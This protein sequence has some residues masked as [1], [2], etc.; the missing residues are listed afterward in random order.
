M[1]R[2][3]HPYPPKNLSAPGLVTLFRSKVGLPCSMSTLTCVWRT[4]SP[5]FWNQISQCMIR[6]KKKKNSVSQSC[7]PHLFFCAHLILQNSDFHFFFHFYYEKQIK[8]AVMEEFKHVGAQKTC[9]ILFD[10]WKYGSWNFSVIFGFGCA[11]RQR[12]IEVKKNKIKNKKTHAA[13][14]WKILA[15]FE[16]KYFFF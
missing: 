3:G 14:V 4:L 5:S 15:S 10:F 11:W 7:R 8:F 2:A 1:L 13:S 9:K 16:T 12:P 6:L